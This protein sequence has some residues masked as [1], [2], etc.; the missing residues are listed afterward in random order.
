MNKKLLALI[1]AFVFL[2]GA[3]TI[4]ILPDPYHQEGNVTFA[5]WVYREID[6]LVYEEKP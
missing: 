6:A 4:P 5:V 3:F 2:T 1:I